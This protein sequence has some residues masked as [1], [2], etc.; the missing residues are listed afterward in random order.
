MSSS[1]Q[2]LDAMFVGGGFSLKPLVFRLNL[3]STSSTSASPFSP[4][5]EIRGRTQDSLRTETS[6]ACSATLAKSIIVGARGSLR[7][8]VVS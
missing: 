3:P 7:K 2:L 5:L 4:S 6:R 1:H 8:D